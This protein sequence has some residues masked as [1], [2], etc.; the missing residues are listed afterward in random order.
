MR[1]IEGEGDRV[2]SL[3][4]RYPLPASLTRPLRPHAGNLQQHAG[5]QLLLVEPVLHQVADA[6][7]TLQFA[8]IDDRKVVRSAAEQATIGALISACT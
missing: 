3:C 5:F 2:A 4:L 6:D 7:D 8:A 1:S